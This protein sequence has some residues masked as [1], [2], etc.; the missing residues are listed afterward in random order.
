MP[1]TI[2]MS[3]RASRQVRRTTG[4]WIAVAA[5]L[6]FYLLAAACIVVLLVRG[7]DSASDSVKASLLA[8]FV[9]FGGAGFVLHV[10]GSARL[11]GILAGTDDY[12]GDD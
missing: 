6:L 9:F 10:I 1:S 4:Q 3:L 12:V 8:S 7:L 2:D 11:S 5:A